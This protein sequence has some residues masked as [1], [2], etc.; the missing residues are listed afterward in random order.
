[1]AEVVYV[2][3]I[4]LRKDV[5]IHTRTHGVQHGEREWVWS[6]IFA[7]VPYQAIQ[8]DL[9][10]PTDLTFRLNRNRRRSK[11]LG[12]IA[13]VRHVPF[14]MCTLHRCIHCDIGMVVSSLSLAM[15]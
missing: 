10:T 15:V 5:A 11:Q 12:V 4:E 7:R 2:P 9:D 1:M 8:R 13:E 3:M 6:K 14:Q